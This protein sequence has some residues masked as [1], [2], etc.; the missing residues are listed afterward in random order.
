M[1]FHGNLVDLLI[2]AFIIFYVWE[3]YGRGF[4]SLCL[5]FVSFVG[6]FILALKFYSFIAKILV[7][8]FSLSQGLANAIGF[9]AFGII[10]EQCLFFLGNKLVEKIPREWKIHKLNHILSLFPLLGNAVIIIAFLL[11]LLLAFPVEPNIK[12]TIAE[13]QFASPIVLNTQ[14][15]EKILGNVFGEAINDT[16]NFLTIQPISKDR[17][18][19]NFT[20]TKIIIDEKSEAEILD[21]VNKER[22]DVG[23]DEL[24]V[25]TKLR[26]LARVYGQDMFARGYFSHYN[27]E[28]E[29]P[30][31]RMDE[32]NIV[33]QIAGENLAFAPNATIA[34]QGLM[35]SPGHKANILSPDFK[36]VGIGVIDGGIYGK[37]FVQ[38]FTN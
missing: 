37:M 20:Q 3:G 8:N 32:A 25:S 28:G 33:Y 24:Q 15:V 34:H 26:D 36:I 5:E 2:I 35:D 13:S 22:R 6:G 12:K 38:E 7:A 18:S 16:F 23:L 19:L 31:N 9:L 21:R 29:S 27:P 4:I 11:S 10:L 1:N 17:I 14:Q 30:F